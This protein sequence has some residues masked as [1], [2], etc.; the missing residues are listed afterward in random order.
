M[1]SNL[2]VN[3]TTVYVLFHPT[4]INSAVCPHSVLTFQPIL[5]IKSEHFVK[6]R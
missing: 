2:F 3:T 5:R 4:V 1:D 6:Q